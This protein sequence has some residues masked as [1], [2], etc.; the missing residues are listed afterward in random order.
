VIFAITAFKVKKNSISNVITATFVMKENKKNGFT[1]KNV[2]NVTKAINRIIF[3]VKYVWNAIKVIKNIFIIA[4]LI[5]YVILLD[6]IIIIAKNVDI[7]IK[8]YIE[9]RFFSVIN[10]ANVISLVK[11]II[12]FIV[13]N[14]KNAIFL[15]KRNLFIAL[16]VIYAL[17]IPLH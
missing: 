5:I 12:I 13:T 2:F 7:A 15:R 4:L 11:R 8:N 3:I 16:I 14:A 6:L 17:I 10:A 1:V 9:N